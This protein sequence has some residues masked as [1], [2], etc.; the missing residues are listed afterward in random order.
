MN[1]IANRFG[2]FWLQPGVTSGHML[3]L[4]GG[5][6]STIGLLTFIAL[7]TPF[8]LTQYLQIPQ[9]QQG[10][11]SGWLHVYQEVIAI[12]L[13]GPIGVLA[14][15]IGRRA[16]Y[17]GGLLCMAAGYGLYSYADS[18]PELF[19]YHFIYAV[20]IVA[21]T[22][23]LGTIIADYT[24][25]RSRGIG[26]ATMGVLNGIG[27][28]FVAVGLGQLPQ[29]FVEGGATQEQAG[30][31]AHLIVAGLC[32][33]FAFWMA[34]G[35]KSGTPVAKTERLPV[36][37]LMRSGYAEAL[38]NP[39]IALSYACAF[40]ARSDL[41]LLGTYSV[42]W[43]TTTAAAQG[44]PAAEAL[45]E[46]R[47]VFAIASTAALLWLPVMGIIIDRLN[48]V[49]GVIIAMSIATA[50]YLGTIFIDDVLSREAIPL[51]ILL[52]M[53]QISAF[54]GAQTLIAKEATNETRGSVVGMFNVF[55]A[56]GILISTAVG[57]LL[58]D[59]VGPHAP[60]NLVGGLSLL[61]VAAAVIV[62]RRAPGPLSDRGAGIAL[63]H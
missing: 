18:L 20:G 2:P 42:L 31:Y 34:A 9:G 24:E 10:T 5:A 1:T 60:F 38:A 61:L 11:V 59:N 13:F 58:F 29:M 8:V 50:G 23:M 43:G 32:A 35:L 44:L 22:G 46:G 14:D 45:A 40:I 21:A 37:D 26:V 27:V 56:V 53:G 51:L 25:P 17:V 62:R 33:F 7:S 52:G 54:A 12:A 41:V 6:F 48:R 36:R 63:G 3:T 28:I 4:F 39:R 19:A 47:K 49:T 16:V 15:R 57:G 55:G 30:H